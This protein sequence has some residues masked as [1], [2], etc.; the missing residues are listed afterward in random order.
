MAVEDKEPEGVKYSPIMKFLATYDRRYLY[1]M[2]FI[3]TIYPILYPM[4][5]PI[6]VGPDT[7]V[8]YA[9]VD[10]LGSDDIVIVNLGVYFSSY[11]ELQSGVVATCDMLVERGVKIAL[12][13][14]WPEGESLI[15]LYVEPELTKRGYVEGEDYVVLGFVFT[16]AAAYASIAQDFHG[17]I[18]VDWMNNP[19]T[20]TFLDRVTDASDLSYFISFA[21]GSDAS[22]TN[23]FALKY[24][25]PHMVNPIGVSITDAKAMY[26]TGLVVAMIASTRGGA[27]LEFLIGKPGVGMSSM[28]AF[29][30][31]HYMLI[32]FI[33]MG[34]I[35]YFG[36]TRKVRGSER[37]TIR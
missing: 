37:T 9:E 2:I 33:V 35:G 34:N 26:D 5:M 29:T 14:Y 6:T 19:I 24:G 3:T 23:H 1:L 8:W 30:L 22:A 10:K 36:Y 20:G 13:T 31:G 16:N 18:H 4:G 28:D 25:T 32:I 21:D 15:R 11:M 7:R 27:E 12:G 17:T